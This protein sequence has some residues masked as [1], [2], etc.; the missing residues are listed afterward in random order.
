[1]ACRLCVAASAAARRRS[2]ARA[3]AGNGAEYAHGFP[4][5]RHS[6]APKARPLDPRAC[7]ASRA[8]AL[9]MQPCQPRRRACKCLYY[10]V[11]S[12]LTPRWPEPLAARASVAFANQRLGRERLA[13]QRA[14]F[15]SFKLGAKR[16]RPL[17]AAPLN[18]PIL[19]LKARQE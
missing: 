11:L 7:E 13:L 8:Q 6:R 12:E 10:Q 9:E 4:S 17:L 18:R 2:L 16:E 15:P 3:S 14:C 5:G 19:R 1:M